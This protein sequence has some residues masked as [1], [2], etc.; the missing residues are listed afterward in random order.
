MS[1]FLLID[2]ISQAKAVQSLL[3]GKSVEEKTEWL[4]LHGSIGL[5]LKQELNINI[6]LASP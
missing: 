3:H 2:L 5:K 4:S 6:E 1:T